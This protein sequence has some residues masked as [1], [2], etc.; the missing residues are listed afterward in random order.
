MFAENTKTSG[1]SQ[2]VGTGVGGWKQICFNR[3]AYI[4][5]GNG[6]KDARDALKVLFMCAVLGKLVVSLP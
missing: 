4:Y 1:D 3:T 5:D 6:G 2:H